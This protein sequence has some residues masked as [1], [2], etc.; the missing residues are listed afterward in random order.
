M[1]YLKVY[2]SFNY[3]TSLRAKRGRR[4]LLHNIT[5]AQI[6]AINEVAKRITD[7]TINPM[8]RDV[9]VF[10][11]KQLVLRSLASKQVTV[12]RKRVIL[13]RHYTMLPIMLRT[14]YMIVTIVDE[15]RQALVN[16]EQ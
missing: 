12:A 6:K 2:L 8:R 9:A 14:I 7:G 1:D 13:Q 4:Q 10:E 5:S 3:L 15:I 16:S 11:R